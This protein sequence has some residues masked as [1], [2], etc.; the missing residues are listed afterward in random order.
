MDVARPEYLSAVVAARPWIKDIIRD[1]TTAGLAASQALLT[2]L[3]DLVE[4]ASAAF[5]N[6]FEHSERA[7]AHLYLKKAAKAADEAWEPNRSLL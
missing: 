4:T 1:A 2:R 6:A 5:L 3:K 7:T